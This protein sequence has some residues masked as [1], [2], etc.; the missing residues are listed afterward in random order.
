MNP[1]LFAA[2]AEEHRADLLRAA[3]CRTALRGHRRALSPVIRRRITLLLR[4]GSARQPI[5]CC[6]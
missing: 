6:A 1:Y 4:R 5:L 2:V 3:G